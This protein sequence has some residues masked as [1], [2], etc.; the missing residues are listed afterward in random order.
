LLLEAVGS[1]SKTLE[2]G[3]TTAEEGA[4]TTPIVRE[5]VEQERWDL[6]V[7]ESDLG[8][9]RF[10]VD[11][12]PVLVPTGTRP[13]DRV[14]LGETRDVE[15]AS[16]PGE[17]AYDERADAGPSAAAGAT[18]GET[19]TSST[20][21]TGRPGDRSPSRGDSWRWSGSTSTPGAG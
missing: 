21:S 17:A 4:R 2:P 13:T 3:S 11:G 9:T 8:G 12:A 20:S 19:S 7:G 14:Q 5:T 15:D 18:A 10:E 16:L 6:D 1:T